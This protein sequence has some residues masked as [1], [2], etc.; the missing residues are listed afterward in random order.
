MTSNMS[1]VIFL[2]RGTAHAMCGSGEPDIC[3]YVLPDVMAFELRRDGNASLLRR[4]HEV[5]RATLT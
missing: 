5:P 2:Q 4:A 1:I 3:A